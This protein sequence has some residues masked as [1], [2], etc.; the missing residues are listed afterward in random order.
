MSITL[1]QHD[2]SGMT[3]TLAESVRDLAR[4]Q[5]YFNN[6]ISS[7]RV[8]SGTW[9]VY[10]NADYS[11]DSLQVSP[12]DYSYEQIK[13]SIGNDVISSVKLVDKLTLFQVQGFKGHEIPLTQ[14]VP[15]LDVVHFSNRMSSL[16]V[17]KG[18]WTLYAEFDYKGRSMQVTRGTY[19]TPE[20]EKGIGKDEVSSVKLDTGEVGDAAEII[21]YERDMFMGKVLPLTQSASDLKFHNFND[22]CSSI[23]VVSGK[24]TIFEHAYYEGKS[25]QLTA[26]KYHKEQVGKFVGDNI[27]SSVRLD[28]Y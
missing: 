25:Y 10:Q 19:D 22:M 9:I 13:D 26:G 11:G 12:G 14:S 3:L 4:I 6:T 8:A 5:T 23:I 2:F 21:L 24:W 1:Y 20:I 17:D 16:K 18:T 27:I 28:E 7:I 15:N